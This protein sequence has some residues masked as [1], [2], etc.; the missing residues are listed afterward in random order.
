MVYSDLP[1]V[2]TSVLGIIRDADNALTYDV[3]LRR[4]GLPKGVLDA[5]ISSLVDGNRIMFFPDDQVKDEEK[6]IRYFTVAGKREAI[7]RAVA[8]HLWELS[9]AGML[10]FA[11]GTDMDPEEMYSR[12]CPGSRFLCKG[13][14]EGFDLS[15]DRHMEEWRGTVASI[16]FSGGEGNVWGVL[17]SI[18][19]NDWETLDRLEEIPGSN[20]RVRV[21]VRTSYGLFC[22]ECYQSVPGDKRLPSKDYIEI[23]VKGSY[24]FG[25]PEKYIKYLKSL[26]VSGG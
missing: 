24:F 13:R 17:Y 1:D 12:N 15:F 26:P 6:N 21:P 5:A 9:A 22:A 8:D 10:Y 4:S 7:E 19:K 3:I 18:G 20:R 14:L 16:K 11:Y 25:L 2:K 23:I